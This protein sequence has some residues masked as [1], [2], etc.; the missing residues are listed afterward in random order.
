MSVMNKTTHLLFLTFLSLAGVFFLAPHPVSALTCNDQA[1]GNWNAA[2]TWSCGAI[3]GS[4]DTVT[5]DSHTVTMVADQSALTVTISGGT[6]TMSSYTLTMADDWTYTSG[7]VNAGT[8]LLKFTGSSVNFTPGSVNYYNL[9]YSYPSTTPSFIVTGTATVTNNLVFSTGTSNVGGSGTI[10]L[11]GNLTNTGTSGF[12]YGNGTVVLVGTGNQTVSSSGAAFGNITVNKSS[13][14]VVLSGTVPIYGNWTWTAGTLDAGTST[15]KFVKDFPTFTPGSVAYYNLERNYP[16]GSPGFAVSGSTAIVTNNLIFSTGTASMGGSG[17]ISVGGNVTYSGTSGNAFGS[18]TIIFNGSGSQTIS[19]SGAS[20]GSITVNK[21]SGTLTLSG[22]LSILGNWTH[23]K[24][25]IDPGSSTLSF[26]TAASTFTPGVGP[27]NNVT[28][29]L[30]SGFALTVSG[31]ATILG[32]L[33]LNTGSG[34]QISSGTLRVLGNVDAAGSNATYGSGVIEIAGSGNQT[35]SSSGGGTFPNITVNKSGGVLTMS[36]SIA[37]VGTGGVGASWTWIAGELNAGTSTLTLQ[38]NTSSTFTPG[39]VRYYNLTLNDNSGTTRTMTGTATVTHDLSIPMTS[40]AALNGGTISVEGNIT[41]TGAANLGGTATI[42]IAGQGNQ[43]LSFSSAGYLPSVTINKPS[44]TLTLSGTVSVYTNWTWIKGKVD[45]GTSNVTVYANNSGSFTP[46]PV[47]Y[48]DVTCGTG[49]GG[50]NLY[51]YGNLTVTHTLDVPCN[52]DT[53]ASNGYA[54][55]TNNLNLNAS[56]GGISAGS[57]VIKISGNFTRT[58]GTFTAGTSTVILNGTGQTITGATTFYNLYKLLPAQTTDTLTFT[59]GTTYTIASG[60][61]ARFIGTRGYPL[62]VQSSSAGSAFT[63]TKTGSVVAE[64]VSL[65]DCTVSVATSAPAST[66]VSGN[67]NW[68]F[69]KE[70]VSTIRATGGDYTT[71]SGWEAALGTVDLTSA[72]TKVFSHGGI[73]GTIPDNTAVTGAT[74]GATGT[75]IHATSTQ[76]LI[77]SIGGTPF[78]SGEQIR[79]DVSNYVTSSDT[80]S[81]A[82]AVAEA[83][84]DW[85]NALNDSVTI[86]GETTDADNFILITVP[87]AHQHQGKLKDTASNYYRGFTLNP[88]SPTAI[89]LDNQQSYTRV[90]GVAIDGT[91]ATATNFRLNGTSPLGMRLLSALG[92]DG[93]SLSGGAI[94]MNSLARDG[95]GK[96]FEDTT[97]A[98]TNYTVYNSTARGCAYGFHGNNTTTAITLKNCLASSNSTADFALTNTGAKSVTYSASSDAT[99]DDFGTTTGDR[100]SQTFSFIDTTNKDFHLAPKDAGARNYGLDLLSD[101]TYPILKDID[102]DVRPAVNPSDSSDVSY[103]IGADEADYDIAR[104][105]DGIRLKDGVRLR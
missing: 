63:L 31:T 79:V 21:P 98:T 82:I 75:A 46:G 77:K 99:S 5:I 6:L 66:N 1:D 11:S 70:F 19:S 73:T 24:G 71:L 83:Y 38:A 61:T 27:Y 74:S 29:S 78:Q 103:D 36:T 47:Q 43:T 100:V 65:K 76:I 3:P 33:T 35:L 39:T 97:G 48:Y 8:S 91:N 23:T 30:N 87:A 88:S 10:N 64:Y 49:G 96:C 52:F 62:S 89:V 84:N 69:T 102:N 26:V 14:T 18:G 58:N 80:G 15:L 2:G 72:A 95:T 22:T 94:V 28:L 59:A 85:P 53:F 54:V 90:E 34:Q 93:F 41:R 40:T 13:G 104:A 32:N 4:G 86:S 9:E 56:S 37:V 92:V 42:L 60:G 50:Q 55:T 67:T 25:T 20:I 12:S 17:T 105:K 51:L 68:T 101:S 44:G 7:T 45:A 81:G 16:S 57:S